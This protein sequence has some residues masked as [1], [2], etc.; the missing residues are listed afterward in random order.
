MKPAAL[1]NVRKKG[2]W[3]K[4]GKEFWLG[5]AKR[6]KTTLGLAG[7]GLAS[8]GDF[9]GHPGGGPR[10]WSGFQFFGIQSCAGPSSPY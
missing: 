5:F 10:D 3:I 9:S 4:G 2:G 7:S 8:I 1:P 6:I